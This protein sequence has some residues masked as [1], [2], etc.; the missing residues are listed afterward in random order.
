MCLDDLN[1]NAET[2]EEFRI[3]DNGNIGKFLKTPY[4]IDLEKI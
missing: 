3:L 4:R 2:G 1:K